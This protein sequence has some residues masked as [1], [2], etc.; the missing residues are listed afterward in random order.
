MLFRE[1]PKNLSQIRRTHPSIPDSSCYRTLSERVIAEATNSPRWGL[2]S[3]VAERVVI[4]L[5][6]QLNARSVTSFAQIALGT[7]CAHVL[8]AYAFRT[9]LQFRLSLFITIYN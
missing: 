4:E 2:I 9:Y 5:R 8:G 3:S 1:A 6:I 7:T